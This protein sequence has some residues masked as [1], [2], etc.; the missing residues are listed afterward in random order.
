MLF[1]LCSPP[2]DTVGIYFGVFVCMLMSGCVWVMTPFLQLLR[3]DIWHSS[4]IWIQKTP[5]PLLTHTHTH[6]ASSPSHVS[7]SSLKLYPRK[8]ANNKYTN[9]LISE[10]TD[11]GF[12]APQSM[13]GWVWVMHFTAA[14]YILRQTWRSLFSVPKNA[15]DGA[16]CDVLLQSS[17][18]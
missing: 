3:D 11:H 5:C 2:G 14:G 8:S 12:S 10:L 6:T 7:Q 17:F 15:A 9:N 4:V 1:V 16:I 18:V 13:I